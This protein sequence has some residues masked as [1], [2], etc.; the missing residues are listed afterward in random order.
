MAITPYL[1]YSDVGGALKFLA[2]AFGFRKYGPEM[3]DRERRINHAAM[4]FG[5]DVVM[6]GRPGDTYRNP[7]Q[8]GQATQG[9]YVNVKDVDKHFARAR[10]AGA[11]VI[12]ELVNTPYGDRRCGFEDPEGHKWYFAQTIRRRKTKRKTR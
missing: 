2:R 9:L 4:K 8:L 5:K 1:Y 12:E 6:M 7:K 3:R 11:A 10:K